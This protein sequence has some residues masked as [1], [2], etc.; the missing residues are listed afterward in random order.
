[1]IGVEERDGWGE[2]IEYC[3]CIIVVRGWN[4]INEK[5]IWFGIYG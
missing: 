4:D 5:I 1:M 3:C 2:G